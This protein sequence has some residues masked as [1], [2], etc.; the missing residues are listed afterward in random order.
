MSQTLYCKPLSKSQGFTLIN[1]F[2]LWLFTRLSELL[3][4]GLYALGYTFL[5]R[6][7]KRYAVHVLWIT[8]T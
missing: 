5:T 6:L 8:Y 7:A 2:N 1:I 3:Y 4:L